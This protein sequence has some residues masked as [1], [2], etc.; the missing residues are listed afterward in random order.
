MK[1]PQVGQDIGPT[2]LALHDVVDFPSELTASIAIGRKLDDGPSV[3]PAEPKLIVPDVYRVRLG[4]HLE[5]EP[6]VVSHGMAPF[7]WRAQPQ[8]RP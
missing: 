4:K 3:I 5:E 6:R 1:W 7:I 8:R 2:V